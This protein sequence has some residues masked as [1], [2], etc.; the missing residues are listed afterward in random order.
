MTYKQLKAVID[1]MTE[2]DINREIVVLFTDAGEFGNDVDFAY[3][4][5]SDTLPY[6]T[7]YLIV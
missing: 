2:A 5:E 7:P 3:S 4:D 6:G 1:V